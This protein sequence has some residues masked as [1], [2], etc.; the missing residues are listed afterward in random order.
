MV[1]EFQLCFLIESVPLNNHSFIDQHLLHKHCIYLTKK[2]SIMTF[3]RNSDIWSWLHSFK[4]QITQNRL[5]RTVIS[6]RKQLGVPITSTWNNEN[7]WDVILSEE[8]QWKWLSRSI[9]GWCGIFSGMQCRC[10]QDSK[11]KDRTWVFGACLMKYQYY[12]ALRALQS[13]FM[14]QD[15]VAI[16]FLTCPLLCVHE[17]LNT[18][19]KENRFRGDALNVSL[20]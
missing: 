9:C 19:V 11:T 10:S 17:Y 16:T 3:Y 5:N 2:A 4:L 18:K 1:R 14:W 7:I 15:Y 13:V 8:W 6:V 12:T 20:Q